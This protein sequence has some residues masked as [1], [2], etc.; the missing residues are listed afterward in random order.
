MPL[1]LW[2]LLLVAP[3]LQARR[4]A[5]T[6]SD[7]PTPLLSTGAN[8]VPVLWGGSNMIRWLHESQTVEIG[9]RGI[10][11]VDS[12]CTAARTPT[13]PCE[14]THLALCETVS[15]LLF[16]SAIGD[17]IM[18]TGMVNP[19]LNS[20][21]SQQYA[22]AAS[23]S[24][25][26]TFDGS[27]TGRTVV[28]TMP[29]YTASACDV[30]Q[31]HLVTI[32]SAGRV[33]VVPQ[34]FGPMAY[35]VV[36]LATLICIYGA[37]ATAE[38]WSLVI[39]AA[40]TLTCCL[41]YAVSGIPFLTIEDE[42][43]FWFSVVSTVLALCFRSP[44]ACL[45]MLGTIANTLYRSPE[46][47]YAAIFVTALAV[48]AWQKIRSAASTK[49]SS[50]WTSLDLLFTVTYLCLT[51]EIGLVPQ[52]ADREDWPIYGGVGAFAAFLIARH[53]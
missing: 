14:S 43:H 17:G 52:F 42:T 20:S 32:F 29:V 44:D 16:P 25:D 21:A 15:G 11:F 18:V 37:S 2:L 36:L 9:A 45:C 47:P 51:A 49:N 50:V 6:D 4:I 13:E 10:R 39:C 35:T 19:K 53:A 3:S 12:L 5:L 30:M 28:M 23:T 8:N 38:T 27:G 1:A 41:V 26:S 24:C 34:T 31:G 7:T 40:G 33:M 46:T 48:R 22:D